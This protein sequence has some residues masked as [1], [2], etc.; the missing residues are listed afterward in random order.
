LVGEGDD[1]GPLVVGE[2]L[3]QATGGFEP[4]DTGHA[5]VE[6]HDVEGFGERG[7]DGLL[8]VGDRVDRVTKLP[9]H[10]VGDASRGLAVVGDEHVS[11]DGRLGGCSSSRSAA[12]NAVRSSIGWKGRASL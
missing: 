3:A 11:L 12:W 6:E 5:Q 2:G 10:A 4:I 9:D 7:V 8:A 1:A